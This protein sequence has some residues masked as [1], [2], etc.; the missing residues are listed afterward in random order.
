MSFQPTIHFIRACQAKD[1]M[2]CDYHRV[3]RVVM[4]STYVENIQILEHRIQDVK[5]LHGGA[6]GVCEVRTKFK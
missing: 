6:R 3:L 4:I 5:L 1:K 2:V